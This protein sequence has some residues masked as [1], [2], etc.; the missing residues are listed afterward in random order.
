MIWMT[1]RQHRAEMLV[2]TGIVAVA[3][4]ILLMQGLSIRGLFPDGAAACANS[5]VTNG[6]SCAQ[7]LSKLSDGYGH[8]EPISFLATLMPFVIGAFLGAP[9]S[10]ASS[11]RA[12]GSWRGRRQCRGCGGWP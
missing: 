11:R 9:C 12:P 5:D 10:A 6:D 1:W 3:G 8:P 4:L 7:A 2:L